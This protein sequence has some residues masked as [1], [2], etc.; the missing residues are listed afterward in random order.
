MMGFEGLHLLAKGFGTGSGMIMEP[1]EFGILWNSREKHESRK[2][3]IASKG[4]KL[5]GNQTQSKSHEGRKVKKALKHQQF[6][7]ANQQ[8][9]GIIKKEQELTNHQILKQKYMDIAS[10]GTKSSREIRSSMGF[11]ELLNQLDKDASQIQPNN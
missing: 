9:Q 4:Q 6:A 3:H 8:N 1:E 7:A 10:K 5:T 11:H 2:K